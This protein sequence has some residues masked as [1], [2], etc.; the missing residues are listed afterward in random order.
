MF[1]QAIL[2]PYRLPIRFSHL[3]QLEIGIPSFQS[4]QFFSLLS[5]LDAPNLQSF[6]LE[7]TTPIDQQLVLEL[8]W[9]DLIPI[10]RQRH[11]DKLIGIFLCTTPAIDRTTILL[12]RE[13]NRTVWFLRQETGFL[14]LAQGP[15]WILDN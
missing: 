8:A 11:L 10:L 14:E 6:T 1:D 4:D 3:V 12:V 15:P 9:A 7:S 5:S 2:V 13:A